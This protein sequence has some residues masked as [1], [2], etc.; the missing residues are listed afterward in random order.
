MASGEAW[1]GPGWVTTERAQPPGAGREWACEKGLVFGLGLEGAPCTHL[2]DRVQH[3]PPSIPWLGGLADAVEACH[4]VP[5]PI[6][7]LPVEGVGQHQDT[8]V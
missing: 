4:A 1:K 6:L 3:G 8:V 5:L 7:Q 2:F